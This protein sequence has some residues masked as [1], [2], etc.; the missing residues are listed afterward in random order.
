MQAL[1]SARRL[2]MLF[3]SAPS[4]VIRQSKGPSS[5]TIRRSATLALFS[6]SQNLHK[7]SDGLQIGGILAFSCF[8]S[9]PSGASSDGGAKPLRATPGREIRSGRRQDCN[10][11]SALPRQKSHFLLPPHLDGPLEVS[12]PRSGGFFGPV[13]QSLSLTPFAQ[14]TPGSSMMAHVASQRSIVHDFWGPA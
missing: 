4:R 10:L 13:V 11:P 14:Y 6:W 12:S 7:R 3:S 5:T 9:P 8:H 1:S 2:Y